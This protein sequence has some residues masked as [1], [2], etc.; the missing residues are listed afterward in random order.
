LLFVLPTDLINTDS[1][2]LI[3]NQKFDKVNDHLLTIVSNSTEITNYQICA[4]ALLSVPIHTALLPIVCLVIEGTVS[5]DF[6]FVF[7]SSTPSGT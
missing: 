4:P 2:S 7:S 6:D 1:Q 5:Q 3:A